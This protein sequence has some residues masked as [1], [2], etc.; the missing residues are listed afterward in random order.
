LNGRTSDLGDS[1]LTGLPT[2]LGF[3][4]GLFDFGPQSSHTVKVRV[5]SHVRVQSW[6]PFCAVLWIRIR[7]ILST[8]FFHLYCTVTFNR[9]HHKWTLVLWIWIWSDRHLFAALDFRFERT[10][11][12]K[13]LRKASESISWS[14]IHNSSI[15]GLPPGSVIICMDPNLATD[16]TDEKSRI[17]I[18]KSVVRTRGSRSVPKCHKSK[19]CFCAYH[20]RQFFSTHG[21][22]IPF[23]GL[24]NNFI[25]SS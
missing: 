1:Y 2:N 11:I 23:F 9:T 24:L 19:I 21:P 14:P 5:Q 20:I 10:E 13:W 6:Y 3:N 25:F 18:R 12:H 15:L 4:G 7:K 17:R 8:S 16:A 22:L